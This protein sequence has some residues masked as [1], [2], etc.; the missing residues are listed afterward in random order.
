MAS[1]RDSSAAVARLLWDEAGAR[2]LP[3][4]ADLDRA[5]AAISPRALFRLCEEDP[6]G[7]LYFL[8][9]KEWIRALAATCRGLGP[10]TLEVACGD[11]FVA[12]CL[13]NVAPDLE[14]LATDSGAW[15]DPRARMTAAEA[16]ALGAKQIPG[17]RLGEGVRRAEAVA[18]VRRFEPDVTLA[19]WLPPG[20][21]LARLIR[22]PTRFVL[23]VGAAGGVTGEGA[24]GWR[25]SHELALGPLERWARCRLDARP[26]RGLATRVTLYHGRRHPEF[27][28]ERPSRGDW[29]FQFKPV[30]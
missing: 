12:R 20:P 6:R 3:R 15:E 7:P 8:P 24:W 9:T 1:S 28:E 26:G 22:A 21:L 13:R 17:L 29:L 19:V 27:H 10:R 23:E 2:R 5:L 14:I 16:R 4:T 18:S 25:F 11:G 30:R